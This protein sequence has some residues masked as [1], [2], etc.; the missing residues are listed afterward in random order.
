MKTAVRG[1]IQPSLPEYYS[2]GQKCQICPHILFALD[3]RELWTR[4][5]VGLT[6]DNE[7]FASPPQGITLWLPPAGIPRSIVRSCPLLTMHKLPPRRFRIL[8]LI[9]LWQSEDELC[10]VSTGWLSRLWT[11]FGV[12]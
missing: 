10:T 9:C 4:N 1:A 11:E 12:A 7:R 3:V 6:I 2:K 8:I 5:K